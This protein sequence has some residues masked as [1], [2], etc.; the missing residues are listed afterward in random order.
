MEVLSMAPRRQTKVTLM[1]RNISRQT[2]P[3]AARWVEGTVLAFEPAREL[4]LLR[5]AETL[6]RDSIHWVA[7]TPFALDGC[8]ANNA[9]VVGQR[10]RIHCRFT[11]HE[12]QAD[13][14]SIIHLDATRSHQSEAGSKPTLN[15]AQL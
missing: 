7:A 9:D 8:P 2:E 12:L 3:P 5:N 15:R 14:I 1:K 13:S 4:L 11:D 6:K 10:V